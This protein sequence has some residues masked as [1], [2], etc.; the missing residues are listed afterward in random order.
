[1]VADHAK[2][3][4]MIMRRCVKNRLEKSLP[5]IEANP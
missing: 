1:M 5:L 4:A 2:R 3:I